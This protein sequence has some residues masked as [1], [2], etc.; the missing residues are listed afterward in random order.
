MHCCVPLRMIEEGSKRGKAMV[1]KRQLFMEMS[2]W[3]DR[4]KS[5]EQNHSPFTLLRVSQKSLSLLRNSLFSAAVY[6]QWLYSIHSPTQ[7][8]FT[9]KNTYITLLF[10]VRYCLCLYIVF[11]V[12]RLI[13]DLKISWFHNFTIWHW[14][15][16]L[17][18]LCSLLY[19]TIHSPLTQWYYYLLFQTF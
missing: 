5:P 17:Q 3:T 14:V 6:N 2:E 16:V 13:R 4:E 18:H 9:Y 19:I 11:S 10:H 12:H 7:S 15:V 1:E 8:C